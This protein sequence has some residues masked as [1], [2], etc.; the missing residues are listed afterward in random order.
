[1]TGRPEKL[2]KCHLRYFSSQQDDCLPLGFHV[3]IVMP[4]GGGTFPP[5]PYNMSCVSSARAGGE[6]A[7]ED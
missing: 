3:V 7:Q 4:R 2:L 5:N 6:A 1:M